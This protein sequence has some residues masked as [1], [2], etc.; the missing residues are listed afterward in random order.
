M[1]TAANS[2]VALTERMLGGD[3]VA[4]AR[5]ITIVENR[6]PETRRVMSADAG[7][8]D[9]GITICVTMVRSERGRGSSLDE[10]IILHL[11]NLLLLRRRHRPSRRRHPPSHRLHLILLRLLPRHRQ[12]LPILHR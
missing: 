12:P 3:R 8:T 6:D 2:L 11:P 10:E 4:L 7:I 5:L 9:A 1:E